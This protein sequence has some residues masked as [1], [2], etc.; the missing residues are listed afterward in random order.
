MTK[1]YSDKTHDQWDMRVRLYKLG[2]YGA[3]VVTGLKSKLS[4]VVRVKYDSNHRTLE[5]EH[6]W[7]DLTDKQLQSRLDKI[8]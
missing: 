7:D 2:N 4:Q 6:C 3:S 8:K 1:P 5:Y